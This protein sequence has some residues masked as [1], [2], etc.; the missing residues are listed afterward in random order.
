[1]WT[2]NTI[3]IFKKCEKVITQCHDVMERLCEGFLEGH[4]TLKAKTRIYKIGMQTSFHTN[5]GAKN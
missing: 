3:W 1:M 5:F 4:R 2:Q